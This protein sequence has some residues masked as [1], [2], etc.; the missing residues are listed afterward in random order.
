MKWAFS[1]LAVSLLYLLSVPW[2]AAFRSKWDY[3]PGPGIELFYEPWDWLFRNAPQ[4]R[5]TMHIYMKW[6]H[7]FLGCYSEYPG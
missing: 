6:C 1:L 4:I 5:P 7:H 3:E 2:V